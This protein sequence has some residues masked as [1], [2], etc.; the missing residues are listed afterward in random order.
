MG[1]YETMKNDF[2]TDTIRAITEFL[3]VQSEYCLQQPVDLAIVM[4]NDYL[5]TVDETYELFK[6][7]MIKR[8]VL[9]TGYNPTRTGKPEAERFLERWLSLG[10]SRENVLMESEATNTKENLLYSY[11]MINEHGGFERCGKK[12][13]FVGKAFALRRILMSA[14]A[15]GYPR[16]EPWQVYGIVD[17]EGL[18]I[19][20]RGWWLKEQA[21]NRVFAELERIAKYSI[22]G[23]L[24]LD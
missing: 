10:G 23:D 1:E 24:S 8:Y 13:L 14:A 12:I 17:K 22:T 20:P 7:G 18:N 15:V 19:S 9:F 4:G 21:R 3:F 16:E 6:N 2:P 5:Q 11:R